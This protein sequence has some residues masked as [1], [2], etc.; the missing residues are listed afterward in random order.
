MHTFW[1][2]HFTHRVSLD[3]L[4][5]AGIAPGVT[6]FSAD[7]S[8]IAVSRQFWR[9]SV[10]RTDTATQRLAQ[11]CSGGTGHA[12]AV[13]VTYDPKEV[14][15]PC[16]APAHPWPWPCCSASLEPLPRCV[17]NRALSG[18]VEP[19]LLLEARAKL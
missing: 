9:P 12:E 1:S 11:V 5:A 15:T 2:L 3:S 7:T 16:T 19:T 6:H 14:M 17:S 8:G 18:R 4:T 10:M 13:Q